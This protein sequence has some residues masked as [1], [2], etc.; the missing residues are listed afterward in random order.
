MRLTERMRSEL[1]QAGRL[2][3]FVATRE[4]KLRGEEYQAGEGIL[5][6]F[7]EPGLL[8]DWL[9]EHMDKGGPW[10]WAGWGRSGYTSRDIEVSFRVIYA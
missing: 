8:E 7:K 6:E 9:D 4:C 5:V 3:E 10:D 1:T 2:T